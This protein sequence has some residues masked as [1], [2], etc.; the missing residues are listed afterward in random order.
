MHVCVYS[1]CMY[2]YL[3]VFVQFICVYLS[4][5]SGML[6]CKLNI[7][8]GRSSQAVKFVQLHT[9]RDTFQLEPDLWGTGEVF[10]NVIYSNRAHTPFHPV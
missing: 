2:V 3:K 9:D 7:N 10:V 6:C 8:K 4:H 1:R 5:M